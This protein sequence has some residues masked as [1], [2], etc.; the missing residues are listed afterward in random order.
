MR[1]EHDK[2]S[3]RSVIVTFNLSLRQI[4]TVC[5][6]INVV[7]ISLSRKVPGLMAMRSIPDSNMK[8]SASEN[9]LPALEENPL[10]E[11]R[12]KLINILAS[13]SIYLKIIVRKRL[14]S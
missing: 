2:L 12:N 9:N 7:I 5:G 6:K 1:D 8:P 3:S 13:S 11:R 4:S 14:L 10:H